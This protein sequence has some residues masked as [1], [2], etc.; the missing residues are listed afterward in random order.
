M[1]QSYQ[2]KK[3]GHLSL[4]EQNVMTAEERAWWIERINKDIQKQNESGGAPPGVAGM[5]ELE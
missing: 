2:L 4:F 3:F 1:E 5:P